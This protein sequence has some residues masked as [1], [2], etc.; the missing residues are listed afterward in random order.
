MFLD[1]LRRALFTND[2]VE[3]DSVER[4]TDLQPR[5]EDLSS[6]FVP[7]P[8]TL[9]PGWHWHNA[10]RMVTGPTWGGNLEILHWN[11][12][13]NRWI[14]VNETYAGCVLILETSEEMP[15]TEEVYFMLRD[16]GERGLLSQ[17]PAVVIAKP[18]AWSPDAPLN[19]EHRAAFRADQEVAVLRALHEYNPSAMAVFGPDFGHTDPQLVIPYGGQMTV[20]GEARTISITY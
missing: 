5:W 20:D 19:E 17:F 2:T 12:A 18:K 11:L 6:L 3:I 10:D 4:F 16:M 1:S 13:A 15:S 14:E 8:T 9:D 7:L